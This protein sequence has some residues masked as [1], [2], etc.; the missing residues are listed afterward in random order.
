MQSQDHLEAELL[1]LTTALFC[2]SR[3]RA[4]KTMIEKNQGKA[5]ELC[6]VKGPMKTSQGW[7]DQRTFKNKTVRCTFEV[8]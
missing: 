4:A 2:L 5:G 7:V 3:K 8:G 6:E 1:H